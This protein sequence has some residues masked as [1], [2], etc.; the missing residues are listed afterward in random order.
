MDMRTTVESV[1]SLASSVP[2]PARSGIA[3]APPTAI[4]APTKVRRLISQGGSALI[5]AARAFASESMFIN[6]KCGKPD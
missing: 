5:G 1:A 6:G 4:D 2:Q 3:A